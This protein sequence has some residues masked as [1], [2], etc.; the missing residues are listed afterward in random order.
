MIITSEA[1]RLSSS[2]VGMLLDGIRR[3]SKDALGKQCYKNG[4]AVSRNKLR[5]G[6]RRQLNRVVEAGLGLYAFAAMSWR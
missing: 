3:R 2:R 1:A 5:T 4:G 6:G